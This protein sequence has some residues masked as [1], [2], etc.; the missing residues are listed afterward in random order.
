MRRLSAVLG[1]SVL[2]LA[3]AVSL[4]AAE[5]KL[6]RIFNWSNYI[7][8]T[9]LAE[10]EKSSGIKVV[11]DTYD[12]NEILETKLLAG[13]TGYD[14]VFPTGNFLARQISAGIFRP[15]DRSKITNWDKLDPAI[16]KLVAQYDP[17]NVHGIPYMWGT[18]G[19]AYNVDKIK[20]RMPDAPVD[21][22]RMLFD[23]EVV[24]KFADCGVFVLNSPDDV[25]PTAL[26]FLGENPDSKDPAVIEK[27]LPLLMSI[28][29]YIRKFQSE[30]IDG[31][32]SGDICLALV[33]SGDAMQAAAAAKEAGSGVKVAYTIPKEGALM[34]FDMMAIPKD[35]P[36]PDAAHAFI[37]FILQPQIIARNSNET[38]YANAVPA[39]KPYLDPEIVNN[40]AILPPA[41]VLET[42]YVSTPTEQKLQRVVTGLWSKVRTGK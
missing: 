7:D 42:L 5:D 13:K 8:S 35:A 19:L 41:A 40:P 1:L 18:S 36:H 23:P 20:E 29:P 9:V 33:Y 4:A 16:M 21:S 25:I 26:R 22:W 38:R 15:L 2:L 34:W 37:N 12:T 11:Y 31:L 30:L 32:A 10:F 17:G 28:R 24:K 6:V 14:L 3:T 39:S 27:T